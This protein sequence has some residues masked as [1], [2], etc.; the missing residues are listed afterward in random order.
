[1]LL[2]VVLITHNEEGSI[3][4]TLNSV[5]PLVANGVGEILVVDSG[6]TD[7]TIEIAKSF[8][9]K[10]F[11]EP[12]KGFAA[13]KNSVIEKAAGD[14]ILSLDADEEVDVPLANAIQLI[15]SKAAGRTEMGLRNLARAAGANSLDQVEFVMAYEDSLSKGTM[16]P[17][18]V[19]VTFRGYFI[20]RKNHFLG[21]WIRRGGF[22]PDPK[23][24]L[25]RR[26]YGRFQSQAVHENLKVDGYTARITDGALVH[27]C[28]PTMSDYIEHMNRYS[29]LGAQMAVERGRRSG[30]VDIVLRPLATF[31]YNYVI[32]LGFL[33]GREGLLLHLNHAAYVFWKYARVWELAHPGDTQK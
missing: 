25:F 32:R 13:Q 21:R 16:Q 24:R 29:S 5:A 7:R 20:S 6:S 2:S 28:Y 33:D 9:A 19:P 18:E 15:L 17:D 30:P 26:G 1:M 14:W 22:W 10:V 12:W 8:G 31:F 3:A 4:R 27:H 11:E 23:L